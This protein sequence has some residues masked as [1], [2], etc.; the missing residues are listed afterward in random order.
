MI[1]VGRYTSGLL[2]IIVGIS[3]ILEL[4]LGGDKLSWLLTWWPM[5]FILLGLEYL[6]YS[7]RYRNE[8]RTMKLDMLGLMISIIISVL[9]VGSMRAPAVMT[10]LRQNEIINI[11]TSEISGH[12]NR[13]GYSFDKH[14]EILIDSDTTQIDLHNTF[15]AVVIRSGEVQ[16]MTI[17]AKVWVYA[18]S[19]QEAQ[20]IGD[21]TAVQY[22]KVGKTL[23]IYAEG[24]EYS[25]GI[26]SKAPPTIDLTITVPAELQLET[27]TIDLVNGELDIAQLNKIKE[28]V[29]NITNGEVKL[30]D[31][32]SVQASMVNGDLSASQINGN[33]EVDVTHGAVDVDQVSGKLDVNADV[34]DIHIIS[35]VV[36]GNWNLK[37]T[38]GTMTLQLPKE[39]NYS[40][41][42]EVLG[43]ELDSGPFQSKGNQITGVVGN[44]EYQVQASTMGEIEI[45]QN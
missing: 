29:V 39:G 41:N 34:S 25:Y 5:T 15:G 13:K 23:E 21:K 40:V 8:E 30:A 16:Q 37:S 26:G 22:N 19:E 9:I 7:T 4:L 32:Q 14:T 31:L 1:K 18:N 17:E 38:I 11:V 12:E 6:F 20:G 43:E 42:T 3:I 28:F 27:F 10:M 36:G 45:F 2:L 35:N 24:P 44:G 33:L